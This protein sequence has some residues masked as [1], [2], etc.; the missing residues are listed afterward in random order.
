MNHLK[1]KHTYGNCTVH[2]VGIVVVLLAS[3]CLW[4][5]E[6]I[7]WSTYLIWHMFN[8]GCPF[9]CNPPIF[10][11]TCDRH[12]ELTLHWLGLHPARKSKG[13]GNKSIRSS[14]WTS[15]GHCAYPVKF[16]K[17]MWLCALSVR[18]HKAGIIRANE[19]HSVK[20]PSLWLRG[21]VD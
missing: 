7:M 11:R 15:R 10:I 20:Q 3:H 5:P 19:S 21:N 2:T 17:N 16:L 14:C 18:A 4:S 1:K 13:H 8:T 9:W 12:R 6:R